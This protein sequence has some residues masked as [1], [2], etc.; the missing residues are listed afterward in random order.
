MRTLQPLANTVSNSSIF[1]MRVVFVKKRNAQPQ[2]P[3]WFQESTSG[4]LVLVVPSKPQ[5]LI[6]AKD[7]HPTNTESTDQ[8]RNYKL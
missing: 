8:I 6:A 7:G 3:A 4:R 2:S 1:P 5:W